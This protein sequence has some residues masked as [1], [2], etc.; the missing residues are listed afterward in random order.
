MGGRSGGQ[1]DRHKGVILARHGVR[2]AVLASPAM[3]NPNPTSPVPV[4]PAKGEKITI[5]DGKLIVP[6]QPIIPFI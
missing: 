5:R 1:S 3:A 6:D 4:P 2:G